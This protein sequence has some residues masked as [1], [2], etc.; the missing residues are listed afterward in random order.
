MNIYNREYHL[1]VKGLHVKITKNKTIELYS[2][3]YSVNPLA[4]LKFEYLEIT[5][6]KKNVILYNKSN[7]VISTIYYAE[8][9]CD[10]RE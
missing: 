2:K 7:E 5:K 8:Q 1:N 9:I 10:M 3:I 4:I 6:F